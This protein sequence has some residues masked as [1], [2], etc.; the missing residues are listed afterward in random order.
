MCLNAYRDIWN[1]GHDILK[2][3]FLLDFGMIIILYLVLLF[4]LLYIS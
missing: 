4:L 2:I 1:D 3:N